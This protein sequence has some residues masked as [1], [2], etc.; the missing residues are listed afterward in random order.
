MNLTFK[1]KEITGILT[2]LPSKEV[3]FED[4]M[5][6]YPFSVETSLKLKTIMGFEKRRIVEDGV[7]ASDLC[8][9]GLSYLFDNKLLNKEDIDALILVTQT[10]D[11]IVPPT[12]N[13]IQGRFGLKEDMIC[14]DINQGCTGFVLGLMQ[15]FLLLDQESIHKVVLM[16]ADVLS[17]KVSRK[18]RNSN[19]LIGDGASITIVERSEINNMIYANIKMDGKR[20]FAIH[21]PAGGARKPSCPETAIVEMDDIGN[22]RSQDNLVMKGDEVFMFAQKDVPPMIV[23]LLDFSN[24][25]K[26][27]VDYFMFHQPNKFMLNKLAD[28]LGIPRDKMPSNVVENLGNS[29][30]VSI[31]ISMTYNLG[32]RLINER[33]NLCL[34]GFGAGLNWASMILEV[35]NLNFN[36]MIF[37]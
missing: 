27:M 12:S 5:E 23:S 13:V 28:K 35:G 33:L 16:N 21:I 24:Q 34:A 8:I 14:M 15:A 29:S 4:E 37:F 2:V 6:N 31:P 22:M 30:G 1:N 9:F 7:C 20:A 26:D 19:P 11:Y 3:R 18:D 25:T 17:R 32:N 36:G 10:P